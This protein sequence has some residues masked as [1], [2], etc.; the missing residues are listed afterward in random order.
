MKKTQGE[1]KKRHAVFYKKMWRIG[2]TSKQ[3]KLREWL[4]G[5]QAGSYG[6]LGPQSNVGMSGCQVVLDEKEGAGFCT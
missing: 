2:K 6:V 3:E 1:E 5:K 4:A